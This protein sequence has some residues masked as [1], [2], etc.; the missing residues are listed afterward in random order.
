MKRRQTLVFV[1]LALAVLI[2]IAAI[3]YALFSPE[4]ADERRLY[5]ALEPHLSAQAKREYRQISDAR[6]RLALTHQALRKLRNLEA[7]GWQG[8][9]VRLAGTG[10]QFR[11]RLQRGYAELQDCVLQPD[12]PRAYF[13]PSERGGSCTGF[14]FSVPADSAQRLARELSHSG[15]VDLFFNGRLVAVSGAPIAIDVAPPKRIMVE[16]LAQLDHEDLELSNARLV[17][18]DPTTTSEVYALRMADYSARRSRFLKPRDDWDLDLSFPM[19]SYLRAFYGDADELVVLRAELPVE[20]DLSTR[21]AGLRVAGRIVVLNETMHGAVLN[22]YPLDHL[23]LGI[24]R[25][26]VPTPLPVFCFNLGRTLL[27]FD[28]VER[29]LRLIGGVKLNIPDGLLCSR[30]VDSEQIDWLL[31]SPF[32]ALFDGARETFELQD[33]ADARVH[34]V[35]D[36]N[37]DLYCV[38]VAVNDVSFFN[39]TYS[40]TDDR[41]TMQAPR[42]FT[43]TDLS[44]TTLITDLPAILSQLA[45]APSSWPES[46]PNRCWSEDTGPR[47]RSPE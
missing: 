37:D 36:L 34:V 8:Y 2:A 40:G 31:K 1:L 19:P 43:R 27:E 10:A 46:D 30:F 44:A 13:P 12:Y 17:I 32:R 22:F 33:G 21:G 20:V 25:F 18:T 41:L 39:L 28:V 16:G 35:W 42:K 4:K 9:G 11:Y 6:T 47:A 7:Q 3:G 23:S 24:E 5:V 29:R 14:R 45:E 38:D 26:A 15:S